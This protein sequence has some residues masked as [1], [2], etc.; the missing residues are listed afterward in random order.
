MSAQTHSATGMPGRYATALFEL[1]QEAGQT[2]KIGA[3]LDGF[4]KLLD[5]SKDLSRLVR[6]PVFSAEEQGAAL[7]AILAKAGAQ[8]LTVNFLRLIAR[9]R[10]LFAVRDMIGAFRA[11]VAESRGEIAAE[12]V[13]AEELSSAQVE[14]LKA[15]LKASVGS[16]V[17]LSRKVDPSILGGLI[18]RVGS[19]MIDSS[20]RTKLTNLKIAMKGIG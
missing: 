10:R 12:V 8:K 17:Q 20:L 18:V 5:E 3:D 13:S 4:A 15:E 1:A 9:N 2:E 11:L 16:D 7:D 14:R 6:S 19:R